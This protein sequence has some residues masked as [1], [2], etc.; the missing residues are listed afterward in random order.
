MANTDYNGLTVKEELARRA[1]PVAEFLRGCLKGRHY[2]CEL[3]Q[4]MEYSLT[5]GGKRLRPVLCLTAGGLFGL[6]RDKA[7]P[8]ASALEMIHTYSL[9]HDDLP[10]MDNDDLRRGKPSNHKQ[11]GEAMAILAGDG[12]LTEAFVFMASTAADLGAG[13]V[14]PALAEV[15]RAAGAA[16]MVGGQALDMLYTGKESVPLPQLK[17]MHARKTG[18][19]ITC[20]CVSGAILAG[21]GREEVELLRGYGQNVGAAFQIADDILDV[22]GDEKDLGKPVGSDEGQGK[23]TYPSLLGIGQSR[24]LAQEHVD[25]AVAALRGLTGDDAA[26]LARLAQFVVDRVS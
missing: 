13:R 6:E 4:A 19:L 11:F 24:A 21:A 9:V 16:G 3:L 7:L 5:A 14:L 8:F 18:A 22:V 2:P 26:F 12:L 23:T 25:Q 17:D 15:A 1:E 10:A 20:S